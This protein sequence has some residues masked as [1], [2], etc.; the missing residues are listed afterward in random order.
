[1]WKS[2][3]VTQNVK[4]PAHIRVRI[5]L[6]S[7][8]NVTIGVARNY[9]PNSKQRVS[10]KNKTLTPNFCMGSLRSTYLATR[11]KVFNFWYYLRPH[12]VQKQECYQRV[13][14]ISIR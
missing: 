5:Y 13:A 11:L 6:V 1:M 8:P 10:V 7:G 3:R 12:T 2:Y 9:N 4:R 14:L